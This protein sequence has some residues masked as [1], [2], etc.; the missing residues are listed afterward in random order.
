MIA[1]AASK[2]EA[3]SCDRTRT[4]ARRVGS[5][6]RPQESRVGSTREAG[7]ATFAGLEHDA[8]TTWRLRQLVRD[9][10]CGRRRLALA[11]DHAFAVENEDV[12]LV[13]RDIEP[14][15][16]L[17]IGSRLDLI[18]LGVRAPTHHPMFKSSGF[19]IDHNSARPPILLDHRTGSSLN[20][21]STC[22]V[23][24][25]TTRSPIR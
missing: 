3:M 25:S 13:H 20:N 18:D 15:E 4:P 5:P 8:T 12:G 9:R 10:L 14:G 16:I 21:S 17:L 7:S 1:E 22:D 6:F 2:S 23:L 24:L 11:N 19:A